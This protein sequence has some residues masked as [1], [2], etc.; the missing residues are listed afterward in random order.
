MKFQDE[1]FMLD[2][3]LGKKFGV[4]GI[5]SQLFLREAPSFAPEEL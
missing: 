4:V 5:K 2:R 3:I 1:N